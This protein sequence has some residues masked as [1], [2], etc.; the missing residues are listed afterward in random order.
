MTWGLADAPK[1][2]RKLGRGG[3][4]KRGFAITGFEAPADGM[5]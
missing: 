1:G 4:R 3:L 2:W 5:A